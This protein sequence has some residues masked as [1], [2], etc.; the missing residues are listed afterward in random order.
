MVL[1]VSLVRVGRAGYVKPC[2]NQESGDCLV[3]AHTK[4]ALSFINVMKLDI[5]LVTL[6]TV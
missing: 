6:G 1:Q 5:S 3:V 2:V 4:T